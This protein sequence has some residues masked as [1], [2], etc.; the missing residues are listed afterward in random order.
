MRTGP[1]G[2]P[3]LREHYETLLLEVQTVRAAIDEVGG[4]RWPEVL[5]ADPG[6]RAAAELM[7]LRP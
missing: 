6:A 7:A 1:Q 3:T 2:A 5:R 4:A